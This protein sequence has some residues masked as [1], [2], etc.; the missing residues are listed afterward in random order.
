VIQTLTCV[1]DISFQYT[2]SSQ[3]QKVSV[4]SAERQKITV[5]YAQQQKGSVKPASKQKVSLYINHQLLCTDYYLF[6]KY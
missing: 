2:R 1:L 6:I 3:Q 4:R 5:M